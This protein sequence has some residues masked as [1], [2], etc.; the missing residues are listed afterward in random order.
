MMAYCENTHTLASAERV[1]YQV[2]VPYIHADDDDADDDAT[3]PK[4]ASHACG[5]RNACIVAMFAV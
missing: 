4:H 5:E 2:S 3:T 1:I